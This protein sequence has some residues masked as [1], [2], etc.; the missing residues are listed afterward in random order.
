MWFIS[1]WICSFSQDYLVWWGRTTY[2]TPA[3]TAAYHD[4]VGG[5]V[6][7]HQQKEEIGSAL[8]PAQTSL[9][10]WTAAMLG[11]DD[12]LAITPTAPSATGLFIPQCP[13]ILHIQLP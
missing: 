10:R 1:F 5:A 9:S 12:S 8:V 4:R 13:E 2:P 6:Q 3:S 11:E 7:E